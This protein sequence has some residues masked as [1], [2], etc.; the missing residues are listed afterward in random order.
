[1]PIL[2]QSIYIDWG[3]FINAVI[4]FLLIA[5]ILFLIIKTINK[6]RAKGDEYKQAIEK[7]KAEKEAA[8]LA[9]QEAEDA[10]KQAIAAGESAEN[11]GSDAA[12]TSGQTK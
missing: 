4:N 1:M 10:K 7:A 9:E 5:L 6:I 3:S 12:P 8:R 11:G 2:E